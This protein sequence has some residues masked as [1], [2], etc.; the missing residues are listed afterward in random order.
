MVP[1]D[2]SPQVLQSV[3]AL[4]TRLSGPFTLR[5]VTE[6]EEHNTIEWIDDN[7]ERFGRTCKAPPQKSEDALRNYEKRCFREKLLN[8]ISA[9][10]PRGPEGTSPLPF[11][12][13]RFCNNHPFTSERLSR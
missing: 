1:Q 12:L 7:P 3:D 6:R 5:V 8:V 11:W 10:G 13:F 4:P 9:D 2:A